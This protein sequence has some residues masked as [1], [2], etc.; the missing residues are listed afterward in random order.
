MT[1]SLTPLT[2]VSSSGQQPVS[3]LALGE[4]SNFYHLAYIVT[5]SQL[6][7]QIVTAFAGSHSQKSHVVAQGLHMMVLWRKEPL[8]QIPRR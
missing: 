7:G 6:V 1:S 5:N 3:L 2:V 4:L 8:C